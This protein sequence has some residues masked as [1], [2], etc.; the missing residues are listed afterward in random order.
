[1]CG[2]IRIKI[3][4]TQLLLYTLNT[5]FYHNPLSSLRDETYGCI[6]ALQYAFILCKEPSVVLVANQTTKWQEPAMNYTELLKLKHWTIYKTYFASHPARVGYPNFG[7][8]QSEF[9]D[10]GTSPH[11]KLYQ[12]HTPIYVHL[13]SNISQ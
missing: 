7:S 3:K 5:K 11:T 8:E 9:S 12:C 10:M 1:M 2:L 4:F 6:P 13:K